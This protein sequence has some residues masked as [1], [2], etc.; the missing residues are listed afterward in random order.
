MKSSLYNA[1]PDG[2]FLN[3]DPLYHTFLLELEKGQWS[4]SLKQEPLG[5]CILIS[6][7][8]IDRRLS[9]KNSIPMGFMCGSDISDGC[10]LIMTISSMYLSRKGDIESLY[11]YLLQA[12]QSP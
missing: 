7:D 5:P 9:I 1:E 10:K 6:I 12:K 2:S 3:I 11:E 8:N 4:I